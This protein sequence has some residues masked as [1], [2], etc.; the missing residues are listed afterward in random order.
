MDGGEC[1]LQVQGIRPFF[2]KKFDIAKYLQYKYLSD[3]DSKNVFDIKKFLGRRLTVRPEDT[4][5]SY[6]FDA[7]LS[8]GEAPAD[9]PALRPFPLLAGWFT[10]CLHNRWRTAARSQDRRFY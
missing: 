8:P 3:S 1:I 10:L 4:F 6:E 5:E 9:L 7:P 2:N